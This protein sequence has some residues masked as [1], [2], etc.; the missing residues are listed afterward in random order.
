MNVFPTGC[1]KIK[2]Y[3][4]KLGTGP[5]LDTEKYENRPAASGFIRSAQQRPT[6]SPGAGVKSQ[7]FPAGTHKCVPY[8]ASAI[9]RAEQNLQA[10]SLRFPLH[11]RPKPPRPVGSGF[12]SRATWFTNRARTWFTLFRQIM[13]SSMLRRNLQN[14]RFVFGRVLRTNTN[15]KF[16]QNRPQGRGC[17]LGSPSSRYARLSVYARASKSIRPIRNCRNNKEIWPG[18]CDSRT[19]MVLP[20]NASLR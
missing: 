19:A 4:G 14:L 7:A 5:I 13:D 2:K 12:M 20:P 8:R 6:D 1:G 17:V 11:R 10:G 9:D 15:H 16:P 18:R 3:R